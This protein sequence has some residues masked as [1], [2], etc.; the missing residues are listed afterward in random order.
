MVMIFFH[1]ITVDATTLLAV[2][3][4]ELDLIAVESWLRQGQALVINPLSL[5]EASLYVISYLL[6][7]R[8]LYH[9]V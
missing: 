7:R 9:S 4:S 6:T 8:R 1:Q 3:S 5:L 2:T